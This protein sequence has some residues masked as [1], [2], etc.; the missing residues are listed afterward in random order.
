MPAFHYRL[1]LKDGSPAVPPTFESSTPT[2]RPGDTTFLNPT[3]R[4]R[5]IAVG[6]ATLTVEPVERVDGQAR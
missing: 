4:V 3:N 1:I 6:E 2:W 5:V